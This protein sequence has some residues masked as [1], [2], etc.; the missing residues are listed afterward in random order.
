MR[1]LF[2]FSILVSILVVPLFASVVSDKGV[3][4]QNVLVINVGFFDPM[5]CHFYELNQG[6][7]G[8][9]VWTK[10]RFDW[11]DPQKVVEVVNGKSRTLLLDPLSTMK[12]FCCKNKD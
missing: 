1:K 5:S 6:P 4:E 7:P 9:R 10:L 12:R 11:I 8:V 3:G 2:P